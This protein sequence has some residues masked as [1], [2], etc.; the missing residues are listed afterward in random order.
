MQY[1]L[2]AVNNNLVSD[3]FDGT[4]REGFD[5]FILLNTLADSNSDAYANLG[6]RTFTLEQR[7][8]YEFFRM[9]C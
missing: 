1:S 2:S 5:I 3:S 7:Q 8:A 6:D 4:M 9:H